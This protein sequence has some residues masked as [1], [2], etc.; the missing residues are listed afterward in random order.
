[1][2]SME[3]V[4]DYIL[5]VSLGSQLCAF[6]FHG[7]VV[8]G[9]IPSNFLPNSCLLIFT[10]ELIY[11]IIYFKFIHLFIYFV[12]Q[13]PRGILGLYALWAQGKANKS[14]ILYESTHD[15]QV[16]FGLTF[17]VSYVLSTTL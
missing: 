5:F 17:W 10:F 14:Y 13:F 4:A 7:Q 12:D 6:S 9:F 8:Y 3:L 15:T 2:V 1:M 16:S 11:V